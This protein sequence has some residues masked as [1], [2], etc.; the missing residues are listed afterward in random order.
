MCPQKN[1]TNGTSHW[2]L[3]KFLGL[4]V[5]GTCAGC[6]LLAK[7][8][9]GFED[10][11]RIGSMDITVTRN[12]Y[13]PQ[14]E[15]SE[16]DVD[17]EHWVGKKLHVVHIRAPAIEHVGDGVKVL[18]SLGERPVL[19]QEGNM[20]ACTF[21]P[22]LTADTRVHELFLQIIIQSKNQKKGC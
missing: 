16:T 2:F 21:H 9:V 6:I 14:I 3:C 13:G 1:V 18:A 11:L 10:M 19:V 15:S 5:F 22:E 8:V 7:H 4:P 17:S 12:A 20:L